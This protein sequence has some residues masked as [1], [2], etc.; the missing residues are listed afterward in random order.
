MPVPD[1][2]LD[3]LAC[4]VCGASDLEDGGDRLTCR[5]CGSAYPVRGGIPI[6]MV[7]EVILPD[8]DDANG[9]GR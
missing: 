4:I 8:T 2:L 5:R 9:V 6:M 3:I 7:D 1:E